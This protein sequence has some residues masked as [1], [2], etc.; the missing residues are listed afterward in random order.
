MSC[1]AAVSSRTYRVMLEAAMLKAQLL[2][3]QG[4][5]ARFPTEGPTEL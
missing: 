4:Q 1:Q 2:M 3:A 5:P